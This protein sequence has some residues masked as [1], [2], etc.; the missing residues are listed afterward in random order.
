MTAVDTVFAEIVRA[1]PHLRPRVG[2]P[3]EMRSNRL[4]KTLEL[5][6]FRVTAPEPGIPEAIDGAVITALNEEAVVAAAL[7][8]KG[9]IN[10][11]HTYEAFGT[12]MYGALRQEIIFTNHCLEA[13]RPQRWLSIPLLLTSH[14]WENGKNEQSH[15][16]PNLAEALL[17]EPSQVSRVCFPA[18]FNT[19]AAVTEEVY[20]THGQIWTVVVPKAETLPDLFTPAEARRLMAE[21][22][23]ELTWASHAPER[24]QIILTAVGA[25]QLGVV[26]AASQRLRDHDLSHTVVYLLEPGRFRQP[27]SERE[28]AHQAPPAVRHALFPAHIP[29]RLFVTHTR[30]ETLLGLL[31]PFHTGPRTS[32]LGYISQGGTLSTPGMLFVNRCSWAHC[33]AEAARLLNLPP[34]QLLRPLELQALEGK[35]SPHGVLIPEVTV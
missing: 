11:V 24:A 33:V 32:G 3:D 26:L 18:D 15:Q 8:N 2:N 1:N 12:K 35:R 23:C 19:A 30:P 17:G 27:R 5:L 6:K 25:Y 29:C 21:G 13:G 7:A 16:D 31:G 9:G 10:L 20:Q 22:G 34:T 28:Q 4:L 14:T